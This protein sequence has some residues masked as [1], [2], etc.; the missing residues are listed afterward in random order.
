MSENLNESTLIFI[1]C[2]PV[3][4]VYMVSVFRR[5]YIYRHPPMEIGRLYAFCDFSA[6]R[7][8]SIVIFIL[9]I[10]FSLFQDLTAPR[11][12]FIL[13][14]AVALISLLSCFLKDR[15][16]ENGVSYNN[17]YILTNEIEEIIYEKSRGEYWIKTRFPTPARMYVKV[18][19]G[20]AWPENLLNLITSEKRGIKV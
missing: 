13:L 9:I 19:E 17:I 14:D 3:I 7:K 10:L 20:M 6:R 15:I 12:V 11:I 2:I 16:F 5:I 18:T 4:L 8:Q 1:I